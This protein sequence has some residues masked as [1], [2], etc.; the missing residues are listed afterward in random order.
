MIVMTTG[1]SALMALMRWDEKAP[2]R[3]STRPPSECGDTIVERRVPGW[4]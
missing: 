2:R 4:S 3:R 1:L